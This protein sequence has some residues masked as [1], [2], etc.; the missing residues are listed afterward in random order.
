[1]YYEAKPYHNP[2]R[3]ETLYAKELIGYTEAS[4][5]TTDWEVVLN[6]VPAP[7]KQ[8]A[9]TAKTMR[10]EPVKSWEPL[11]FYK[12]GEAQQPLKKASPV[13]KVG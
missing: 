4:T 5:H 9:F 13:L 3:S 2:D 1:M 11:T 7:P 6:N 10:T 8:K 12:S